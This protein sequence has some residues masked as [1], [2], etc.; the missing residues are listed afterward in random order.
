MHCCMAM[1]ARMA[2]AWVL[3]ARRL[4]LHVFMVTYEINTC[5]HLTYSLTVY[6]GGYIKPLRVICISRLRYTRL[7][8]CKRGGLLD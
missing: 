6:M 3:D 7:N 1:H 4:W 5:M 2:R 8:G